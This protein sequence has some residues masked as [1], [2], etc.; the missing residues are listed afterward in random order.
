M[1]LTDRIL[2]MEESVI[3]RVLGH[4]PTGVTVITAKDGGE[5]VGIVAN[6]VTSV[7]LDPPLMLICPAKSSGTWP[8]LR[9]AGQ[10]CIN[11]MAGH[12]EEVCRR[13]AVKG[14]EDRFEGAAWHERRGMPALDDAVAWIDCSIRDEHDAGD[15]TIVVAD[16]LDMEAATDVEPLVFFRGRYGTLVDTVDGAA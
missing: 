11:V 3:R 7:S 6:S 1:S 8:R 5:P 10:F 13:F 14:A 15:H 9:S 2:K 4:L 12:H 16:I